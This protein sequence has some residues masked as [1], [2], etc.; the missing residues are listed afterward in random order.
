MKTLFDLQG[1]AYGTYLSVY[2]NWQKWGEHIGHPCLNK[3]NGYTFAD[4]MV[5]YLLNP[6]TAG[7][8]IDKYIKRALKT[9]CKGK[10]Q[11]YYELILSTMVM[12]NLFYEWGY[13]DLSK[14][15]SDWYLTLFYDEDFIYKYIT[16]DEI[17][18]M[19]HLR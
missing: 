18:E 11:A 8:E 10:K 15:C 7:A 4:D 9:F 12:S 2:E 14:V 6:K 17:A 19:W 3:E 13:E 5:V 1:I 16:E